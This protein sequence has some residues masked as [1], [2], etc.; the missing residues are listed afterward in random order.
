MTHDRCSPHFCDM[1]RLDGQTDELTEG[2]PDGCAW[3]PTSRCSCLSLRLL[4]SWLEVNRTRILRIRDSAN[5]DRLRS[6]ILCLLAKKTE[7][8]QLD[9]FTTPFTLPESKCG[10]RFLIL[11]TRYRSTLCERARLHSGFVFRPPPVPRAP[12]T[13]GD[14]LP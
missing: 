4:S 5:L 7:K 12:R 13:R 8:K 14:S 3:P 6:K 11:R 1:R 9:P 10:S 2:F